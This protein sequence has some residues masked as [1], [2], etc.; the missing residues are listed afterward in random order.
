MEEHHDMHVIQKYINFQAKIESP[1]WT[2]P[3]HHDQTHT[4]MLSPQ[5]KF[6][7]IQ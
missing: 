1:Q 4:N 6:I 3:I 2:C 7:K 5:K